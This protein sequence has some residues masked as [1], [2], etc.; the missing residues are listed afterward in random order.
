M[1]QKSKA[2]KMNMLS[3]EKV[4]MEHYDSGDNGKNHDASGKTKILEQENEE[5]RNKISN[6][7]VS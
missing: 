6:L 5:L 1:I 2:A 4:I 7:E 3:S